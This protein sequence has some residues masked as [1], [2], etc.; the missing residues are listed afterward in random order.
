MTIDKS[1]QILVC[2]VAEHRPVT[3]EAK[4]PVHVWPNRGIIVRLGP[5]D[6]REFVLLQAP[7][8]PMKLVLLLVR[9]PVL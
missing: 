4:G 7:P 2:V 8:N 9:T 6:E 5:L 1:N 3:T